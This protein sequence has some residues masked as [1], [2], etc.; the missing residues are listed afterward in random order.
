[1]EYNIYANYY[2]NLER[3]PDYQNVIATYDKFL[4]AGLNLSYQD[5]RSS[6]GAVDYEKG[7]KWRI[8]SNNNYVIKTLYPHIYGNMDYGFALPINHSS[9]WFRSSAGY[10]YGN[11]N[12][13]FANFYFGGFG[14]NY[15]DNQ[16]EKRYREY[17][18]FPGV[19]LNGISGTNYGKL[20][21]E[22][23][24]PP[25]RFSNLGFSSFYVNY[26]RTSLFST[27]L[28]SNIDSKDYQRSL[29]NIGAQID[30][31]IIMF[32]H[33]KLTFSAGYAMA[34]EKQQSVVNELMFSLKI[35]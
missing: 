17:Y 20:M 33:L 3:L 13:P 24:L 29:A 1:M 18:S 22:W 25:L 10:S 26:A 8:S 2:G 4:N 27:V 15:V 30:F 19:E 32:F 5:L 21:F 11:R 28:S 9:I 14:N 34:F 12:E 31:K 16:T 6:L 23:N 35:L 7:Y